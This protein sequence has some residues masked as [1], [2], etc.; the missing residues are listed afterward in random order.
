MPDAK[1][2]PD[3]CPCLVVDALGPA[4]SGHTD[5][6]LAIQWDGPVIYR[7][8]T[9]VFVSD[10]R[11]TSCVPC[12]MQAVGYDPSLRHAVSTV[13]AGVSLPGSNPFEA[14]L[15]TRLL[16]VLATSDPA[17]APAVVGIDRL[18]LGISAVRL[19]T[20]EACHP[21][22][23]HEFAPQAP[24][25]DYDGQR[26][27]GDAPL[28]AR[29]PARSHF[30]AVQPSDFLDPATALAGSR[31]FWDLESEIPAKV[32]GEKRL[33]AHRENWSLHW[34]GHAGTFA[35][36]EAIGVLEGLER[37]AGYRPARN[38]LRWRG[39]GADLPARSVG[40][41]EFGLAS[42][43]WPFPVPAEM[44]WVPGYSLRA[45]EV[46]AVPESLVYY[47]AEPA[48]ELF[49][50]ETSS[51]CAVGS[52]LPEAAFYGLLEVIERDSFLI[53][54]YGGIPLREIDP[55]GVESNLAQM[56]LA[57]MRL[58]GQRVRLFDCTVGLPV[59]TVLAVA[60]NE[61]SCALCFGAAS[62]PD[63]QAAILGALS[64]IC[65]D[66]G[67]GFASD[68]ASTHRMTQERLTQTDAMIRDFHAVRRLEDHADM[69]KNPAARH[70]AAFLL[71]GPA[72]PLVPVDMVG[73]CQSAADVDRRGLGLD[74][75][76]EITSEAGFEPI[77]VDQTIPL[78]TRLGAHAAKAIVPGLIPID[79][80]WS[81]QRAL[82]MPRLRDAW[83]A[84]TGRPASAFVPNL[85][86]HP[87]P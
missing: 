8:P 66:F 11:A 2:S 55:D 5:P 12:V 61:V 7:T 27:S 21:S 19:L 72:E 69:F 15:M 60:E 86:P 29:A 43:D 31:S 59:P 47:G 17:T 68:S 3:P 26:W 82:R 84:H 80:G 73:R 22:R 41:N 81:V 32:A 20:R 33:G 23:H 24:P 16:E 76:I 57:R 63:P 74:W 54:W 85:V 77:V 52:T 49:A 39:S 48:P 18:R 51:G 38:A 10:P 46:V 14:E 30:D 42:E 79:F 65:S 6:D 44:N 34:G 9:H 53:A 50:F 58:Y 45:R 83:A 75:L 1:L 35:D 87:F 71:D 40:P 28:A 78:L 62:R 67:L 70:L 36:S 4:P 13:E 56:M 64:E 25:A 37:I